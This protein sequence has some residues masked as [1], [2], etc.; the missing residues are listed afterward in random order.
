MCISNS[1]QVTSFAEFWY[2]PAN[3][4][5]C[6][7]K[8]S[9]F[10]AIFVES[11]NFCS[12]RINWVS[13]AGATLTG[14][15]DCTRNVRSSWEKPRWRLKGCFM[16]SCVSESKFFSSVLKNLVSNLITCFVHTFVNLWDISNSCNICIRGK[17]YGAVDDVLL[18]WSITSIRVLRSILVF[19]RCIFSKRLLQFLS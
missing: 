7:P 8:Q 14:R 12:N 3:F 15:R 1:V 2:M 5:I 11:L 4:Y 13:M 9:G 10:V 17:Y 19:F 16:Q 6:A 18:I